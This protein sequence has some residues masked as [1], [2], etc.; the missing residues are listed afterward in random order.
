M[1]PATFANKEIPGGDGD[2][3]LEDETAPVHLNIAK[4]PAPKK[5]P[6]LS[7]TMPVT[8]VVPNSAM[9][10][11]EDNY[12][13]EFSLWRILVLKKGADVIKNLLRDKRYTV[14]PYV[15]NPQEEKEAQNE[16]KTLTVSKK[17]KW[18][19]LIR[20][21]QTQYSDIF[22]AWIH[23]KAMRVFSESVLRYGIPVDFQATLVAPKKGKHSK[24]RVTLKDLYKDLPNAGLADTIEG[25]QDISGV[26]ADFYS[27]VYFP[28]NCTG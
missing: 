12:E 4:A 27:Y 17:K 20:W 3:A 7:T 5:E 1:S 9:K 19:F 10:L 15:H 16:K 25:E 28:L 13:G 14:R 21:C 8:H 23:V 11:T 22:A 26:G 18:T 24:L 2:K 6:L